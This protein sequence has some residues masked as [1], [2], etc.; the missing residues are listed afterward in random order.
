MTGDFPIPYSPTTNAMPTR[1]AETAWQT[2]GEVGQDCG[3][4]KHGGVTGP[5]DADPYTGIVT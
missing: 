5:P 4:A 1:H 2:G 3:L